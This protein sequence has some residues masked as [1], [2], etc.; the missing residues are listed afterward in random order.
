MDG[1]RRR[2]FAGVA[3]LLSAMRGRLDDGY[4]A[5]VAGSGTVVESLTIATETGE[6]V[7]AIWLAGEP[8]QYFFEDNDGAVQVDTLRL[9]T[10]TLLWTQDGVVFRLEASVSRDEAIEIAGSVTTG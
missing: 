5:K 8:H 2:Q 1:E 7:P 4:F 10:N 9:A 6:T 3:A